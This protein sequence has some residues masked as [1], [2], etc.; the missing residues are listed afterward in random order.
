VLLNA[1]LF[2]GD[3]ARQARGAPSFWSMPRTA[4]RAD[5]TRRAP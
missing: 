1:A 2:G 5:S 3:V 4:A